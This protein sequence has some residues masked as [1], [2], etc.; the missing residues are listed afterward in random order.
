ML[1]VSVVPGQLE[2]FALDD[3]HDEYIEVSGQN[4]TPGEGDQRPIRA[5]GRPDGLA[6]L[7]HESTDIRAL[8]VHHIDLW[9]AAAIGNKGQLATSL[10]IPGRRNVNASAG[11]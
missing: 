8:V 11:R 3:I 7:R 10:G 5:P 6:A 2:I 9:G 4:F 1:I